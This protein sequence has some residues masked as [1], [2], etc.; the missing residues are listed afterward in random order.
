MNHGY[1]AR[2]LHEN[3]KKSWSGKTHKDLL[4]NA[5]RAFT[6]KK[7]NCWMQ[8]MKDLDKEEYFWLMGNDTSMW[9]RH[10]F[11]ERVAYD[12]LL[13]NLLETL[14]SYIL[15]ARNKPIITML[16]IIRRMLMKKFQ[17]KREGMK[18]YKGTICPRIQKKLEKQK[19]EAMNCTVGIGGGSK[20]DV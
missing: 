3:F 7:F 11:S 13:N 18:A 19:A 5:A 10:A 4:W 20:Y 6:E 15:Q 1:F 12:L 16:E 14:N 8:K 9:A 17:K 2:H